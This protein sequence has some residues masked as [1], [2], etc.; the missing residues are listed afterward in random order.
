MR[1]RAPAARLLLL[2]TGIT[3]AY[4]GKRQCPRRQ[5]GG[6]QDH[7]RVC[8]EEPPTGDGLNLILGSP[9]RMRG[10]V[11]RS[12]VLRLTFGITPAYAGKRFLV[13]NVLYYGWDYPRV[14]GEESFWNS[15]QQ[16]QRGSPPRMRGRVFLPAYA[17]YV[18]GITPAYAGK[19]TDI[20]IPWPATEDHPRVCGEETF[21]RRE[22]WRIT[23]SPPRMR[24]RVF[25]MGL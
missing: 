19:S 18:R 17:R 16:A 14:C 5:A 10:R 9:P 2:V 22:V 21:N 12:F 4:A 24:G 15:V 7:P 25:Q 8:G 6:H 20:A 1:G 23:G 11:W 3:P 13:Y